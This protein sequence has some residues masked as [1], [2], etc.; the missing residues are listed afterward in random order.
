MNILKRI[1]ETVRKS[2]SAPTPLE[3]KLMGLR[4]ATAGIAVTPAIAMQST[5]VRACVEVIAETIGQL[6]VLVYKRD[7]DGKKERETDSP[8]YDVLHDQATEWLSAT[9]FRELITRDALMH[10][11]GY[12]LIERDGDDPSALIRL[13]PCKMKIEAA[14]DGEPVYEYTDGA[15]KR[16]YAFTEILH[17]RAPSFDGYCGVSPIWLAREAIALAIVLERH[18]ATLFKNNAQPG[19]VIEHPQTLGDETVKRM[20]QSWN[21]AHGGENA[22]GV[23]ILE[24]GATYKAVTMTSEDAQY[25]EMR[26]FAVEE[27]CRAFRVPPIFVGDYGR[28]TWG[29]SDAQGMQLVTYCLMPWLKRWEGEIRLK[30]IPADKRKELLA[31]FLVDDLLRADTAAR[32]EA[33]SKAIASKFMNPNE[34]RARENLPSYTGGDRF[35]NPN[36]STPTPAAPEKVAA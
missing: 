28:A 30:L 34:A 26:R 1:G 12:G 16:V 3:A 19:G 7:K 5:V 33:Y 24:E 8:L 21:E 17:I 6:P 11:N 10:G 35:E 31:E 29:N 4:Q 36:T 9:E 18:G 14:E 2:L 23:A 22:G 25:L 15:E 13:D 32:Y 27:I 20:E